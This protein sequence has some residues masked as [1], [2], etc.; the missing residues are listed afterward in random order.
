MFFRLHHWGKRF[1]GKIRQL[2]IQ[3]FKSLRR[4]S[5]CSG[6]HSSPCQG[7]YWVITAW[8]LLLWQCALV[9]DW[10]ESVLEGNMKRKQVCH[11]C[12]VC[13]SS[14]VLSSPLCSHIL[15]C[16]FTI[17]CYFPLRPDAPICL[18]PPAHTHQLPFI[19]AVTYLQAV[20]HCVDL[21]DAVICPN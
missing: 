1:S 3:T 13:F 14:L 16:S 6:K 4:W 9:E 8:T 12:F 2:S 10:A 21:G 20:T 5:E 11:V 7:F 15:W 17:C 19:K 18:P